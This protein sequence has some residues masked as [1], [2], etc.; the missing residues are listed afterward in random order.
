M[1]EVLTHR[2][3]ELLRKKFAR[4]ASRTLCVL[5]PLALLAPGAGAQC[6]EG[7]NPCSQRVPRL[8][9]FNGVLRDAGGQPR[10]GTI[11]VTYSIYNEPSGGERLWR[12]PGCWMRRQWVVRVR[13]FVECP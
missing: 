8:V 7:G 9:K 5:W 4:I 3:S 11:G 10:T 6:T 1:S 12:S 13:L 2:G